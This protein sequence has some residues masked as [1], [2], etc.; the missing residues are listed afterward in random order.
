MSLR[1]VRD[2]RPP[3]DYAAFRNAVYAIVARIPPGRVA[4]YGDIARLAG[5]PRGARL[6]GRL[7]ADATAPGLPCHRV[8]A[9]GGALGGYGSGPAFKTAQLAAEGVIVRRGRLAEF[10]TRR[11]IG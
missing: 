7:M 9:A 5:R 8:V 4:T 6:V 3:T 2:R 10:R 11:W 1:R